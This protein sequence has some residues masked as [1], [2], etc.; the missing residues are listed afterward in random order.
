MG[1]SSK[2]KERRIMTGE[3]EGDKRTFQVLAYS[4]MFSF[5]VSVPLF[6]KEIDDNHS[7]DESKWFV[8]N[9]KKSEIFRF[10]KI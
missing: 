2:P 8:Q 1:K 10:N 4:T 5:A 7:C 9:Q 3:H 6:C